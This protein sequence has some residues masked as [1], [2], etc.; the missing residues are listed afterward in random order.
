MRAVPTAVTGCRELRLD[1]VSDRRGSFLKLFRASTFADVGIAFEVRELFVSRSHRGVLRGLHYQGPGADV[2]KIVYCLEGT[3]TD[4]VVDLR[5]GSPTYRDHCVV[6]LDADRANAVYVPKGCAHGFLVTS[7]EAMV[8]YAQTGEHDPVR[9]GGVLWSSA[10][11]A[12]PVTD[13]VLSDRDAAFV[14]LDA[15][16]SPFRYAGA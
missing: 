12:W 4:A 3:I 1:P 15:F 7:D 9:E 16:D 10:G 8:A 13:P 5:V 14:A 11:I 6:E 2:A